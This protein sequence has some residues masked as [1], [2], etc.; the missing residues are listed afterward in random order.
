MEASLRLLSWNLLE[1]ACK[2][3]T[4]EEDPHRTALAQ[5]LIR[6][7]NPDVLVLNEALWC[8]HHDGHRRDYAALFGFE[9]ASGGLY[10]AHWGN[11]ILSRFPIA[12]TESFRIYNRGGLVATIQTPDGEVQ[13]A[14]YHPHPS[15][16]PRHKVQDFQHL[17]GMMDPLLPGF[18]AG[19]FNA[20][21]PQDEPD[22]EQLAKA[23]ERFSHRPRQDCL[24]FIEGGEALFPVLLEQGWRDAVPL[25]NQRHT[26]P[27]ALIGGDLNS[28]MRI[29]HCW[30]NRQ[31]TITE[32]GPLHDPRVDGA[33]DH[34][35]LLI[36][37]GWDSEAGL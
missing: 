19:D 4:D 20:I 23:F 5:G 15:R 36:R 31:V 34:Y 8:E 28:A 1:G 14:T 32:G 9:H 26:M 27:T 18:V 30:V 35:P 12:R 11:V 24:R 16:Y 6:E 13:A 22:V 2:P 3:G 25:K 10:D 21:S 29:D 17:L 37:L 7:L 33:S